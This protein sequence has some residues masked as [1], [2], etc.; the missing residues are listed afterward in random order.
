MSENGKASVAVG[1]TADA[2]LGSQLAAI[3][4]RILTWAREVEKQARINIGAD[5]DTAKADT[6]LKRL[7]SRVKDVSAQSADIQVDTDTSKAEADLKELTARIK[8]VGAQSADIKVDTDT[9]KA[10]AQLQATLAAVTALDAKDVEI[11]VTTS[12]DASSLIGRLSNPEALRSARN[13]IRQ[14]GVEERAEVAQTAA[15]NADAYRSIRNQIDERAAA[16]KIEAREV[17]AVEKVAAKEVESAND[18][19]YRSIRRQIAERSA[20]EKAA[21]AERIALAK[22]EEAA[23]KEANDTALRSIRNQVQALQTSR[24]TPDAPDFG[25]GRSQLAAVLRADAPDLT[26]DLTGLQR[27]GSAL[28]NLERIEQPKLSRFQKQALLWS[29][30]VTAAFGSAGFGIG[31]FAVKLNSDIEQ[32]R[33]AFTGITGSAETGADLVKQLQRFAADTP[34]EFDQLT[35]STQKLLASFGGL[36]GIKDALGVDLFGSLQAVGDIAATL[37]RGPVA[38]ERFILALT[39]MQ[40]KGRIAAEEVRQIAEAFPG[41]NVYSAIASVRGMSVADTMTQLRDKTIPFDEAMKDLIVGMQNFNGAAGAMQRQ[42]QTLAGRLSTVRDEIKITLTDAFAPLSEEVR[43]FLEEFATALDGGSIQKALT[44]IGETVSSAFSG[45]APSLLPLLES[46]LGAVDTFSGSLGRA[47]IP[48][49]DGLTDALPPLAEILGRLAEAAGEALGTALSAAV[50]PLELLAAV[51]NSIP[52]PILAGI[53]SGFIAM[54][55]VSRIV[56]PLAAVT[57]GMLGLF[58]VATNLGPAIVNMVSAI[59]AGQATMATFAPVIAAVG[60]A[61]GGAVAVM[62]ILSNKNKEVEESTK[63]LTSALK[64]HTSAVHQDVRAMVLK[65]LTDSGQLDSLRQMGVGVNTWTDALL[66]SADAQRRVRQAMI[67]TGEITL[68]EVKTRRLANGE[69]QTAAEAIAAA[70]EEYIL[71][72][73]TTL[74]NVAG[75]RE[76]A[77]SFSDLG[78]ATKKSIDDTLTYFVATEVTTEAELARLIALNTLKDGTVDYAAVIDTLTA[79]EKEQAT[80]VDSSTDAWE[81]FRYKEDEVLATTRE[82]VASMSDSIGTIEGLDDAL[83]NS[84]EAAGKLN[85]ALDFLRGGKLDTTEAI[86]EINKLKLAF[87]E[88]FADVGGT[89]TTL[90]LNSE[91]GIAAFEG[92]KT[93]LAAFVTKAQADLA[94]GINP[95]RVTQELGLAQSGFVIQLAD[96]IN[97]DPAVLEQQFKDLGLIVPVDAAIDLARASQFADDIEELQKKNPVIAATVQ[98]LV[99]G[100]FLNEAQLILDTLALG[101]EVPINADPAEFNA[102]IEAIE[103]GDV[104]AGVRILAEMAEYDARLKVVKEVNS[105]HTV[106]VGSDTNPFEAIV[107]QAFINN[108]NHTVDTGAD[109]VKFGADIA[110]ARRTNLNHQVLTGA[111]TEPFKKDIDEAKRLNSL[112]TITVQ[113]NTAGLRNQ[114][115]AATG[116]FGGL[117]GFGGGNSGGGG[118]GRSGGATVSATGGSSPF[119]ADFVPQR[120][121]RLGSMM[122]LGNMYDP[123]VNVTMFKEGGFYGRLPRLANMAPTLVSDRKARS[124]GGIVAFAE[125][126]HGEAFISTDS[127]FRARSQAVHKA[128]AGAIGMESLPAGTVARLVDRQMVTSVSREGGSDIRAVLSE[129]RRSTR[130]IVEAAREMPPITVENYGGDGEDIASRTFWAH[131]DR[132]MAMTA[133]I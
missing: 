22:A 127:K 88:T 18:A 13:Q 91:A 1:A 73:R 109:T 83:A 125:A 63:E 94:N 115:L 24:A 99:D 4:Q 95:E 16:A 116:G 105:Q 90:D 89:G 132:A 5:V 9:A 126:G 41:F 21:S 122:G 79:K 75:N 74:S 68:V 35:G 55:I 100:G 69:M 67:D 104:E 43:N 36:D 130:K 110:E 31:A 129:F 33:I 11:D 27:L 53:V 26:P 86:I 40:G 52:L 61:V 117:L 106:M 107:E 12:G 50:A 38:I 92:A 70:R 10:N 14:I 34:F 131:R 120:F 108:Q 124:T 101:R 66:G 123:S 118:G 93:S 28:D 76:L 78:E 32:V 19:A 42:S 62:S 57:R 102:A 72:G 3:K 54:Q 59:V 103:N 8:Q 121:S 71:T 113:A 96:F 77:T 133:R 128:V 45:L 60:L 23:I 47:L 85:D 98:T 84:A 37:G 64:D 56:G 87:D 20:E 119:T 81:R 39:Q 80:S 25:P 65:N 7:S 15:A 17:A 111:D 48:L 58:S 44:G 51:L 82:V 46:L 114:I 97:I 6:D 2:Q 29:A 49:V 112:L 30:G